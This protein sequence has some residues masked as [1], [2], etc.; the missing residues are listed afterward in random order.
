MGRVPGDTSMREILD[1]VKPQDLRPA[2]KTV[3]R[4]L[5]R[6]KALEE[7]GF[8]AGHDL[9]ALDGTG[10]FSSQEIPCDSC[11]DKP[12]R[13]GTGTYSQQMLG[14]A[15]IHPGKREG[16]P[17]RPEP[18][19]K[20]DGSEQNDCER[21]AAKRFIAKL[22]QDH[23]HLK[24]L[25]TEDRLS[26]HAPHIATLHA[27]DM[28]YI[29]GVEE[30]DHAFVFKHVAEA[31]QAGRGTYYAREDRQQGMHHRC[32]FVRDLP[33][34]ESH[35][36][37]RVNVLACWETVKGHL[38]HCSWGTDL[39]VNPGTVSRLMQGARAR[40]RSANATCNTLKNPG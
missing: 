12:H 15:L 32:R 30:G 13:K 23:P 29:R 11:L 3:F 28:R 40:W 17:V 16:M 34:N 35:A 39:R 10:Y 1:P 37:L 22:R 5:Q 33:L 9:L 21:N 6:G 36:A 2:F 26:S 31:E 14:A 20:P 8:V 7:M 24:V 18:I 25:V 27:H 38:Q 4:H 19:G